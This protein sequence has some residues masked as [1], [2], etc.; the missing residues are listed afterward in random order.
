MFFQHSNFAFLLIISTGLLITFPV[1]AQTPPCSVVGDAGN[2][3]E[4][5]A[6]GTCERMVCNGSAYMPLELW[7]TSGTKNVDLGDD[8]STCDTTRTG[9]LRYTGSAVQ[10]CSGTAW[11]TVTTTS[12]AQMTEYTTVGGFTYNVPAGAT[13]VYIVAIGGGGG[14]GAGHTRPNDGNSIGGGGGGG[15]GGVA[16]GTFILSSYSNPTT[17]AVTV[18]TG[19]AGGASVSAAGSNGNLSKVMAGVTTL[20]SASGG[21]KGNGGVAN[22]GGTGGTAVTGGVAGCTGGAGSAA[23][24][25]CTSSGYSGGG[26]GGGG[27]GINGNGTSWSAGGSAQYGNIIASVTAGAAGINGVITGTGGNGAAWGGCCSKPAAAGVG[28]RGAGGGG[29]AAT[30]NTINSGDGG[31]GG[32]GYVQITAFF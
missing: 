28:G 7:T 18:G 4:S 9:R 1:L 32:G 8:T 11:T 3:Y 29:G 25:A 24:T 20:V 13:S 2:S 12:T 19:G 6:S 17:L 21:N 5:C 30:N 16:T 31:A 26:G 15:S 10:V 27:G 22:A 23:T 14:G